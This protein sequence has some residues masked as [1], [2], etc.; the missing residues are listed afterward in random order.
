VR[1]TPQVRRTFIVPGDRE[2][3]PPKARTTSRQCQT[4][5]QTSEVLETSEVALFP[6]SSGCFLSLEQPDQAVFLFLQRFLQ[7]LDVER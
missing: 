1:R 5:S 6:K 4:G 7:R 2:G 3:R